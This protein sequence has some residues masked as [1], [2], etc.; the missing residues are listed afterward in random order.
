MMNRRWITG[1]VAGGLVALG[2]ARAQSVP[3]AGALD[4][5]RTIARPQLFS[6]FHTPVQE[7]YIWTSE[8]STANKT[9]VIHYVFP[10]LSEKTEPHY[11]RVHFTVAALP[12]HATLYI[13]GPRSA[14][15]YLNGS[16][17]GS[18]ASDLLSPLDMHVFA[19]DVNRWLHTGDNVLALEV[20]AGME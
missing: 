15:I 9:G 7:Q 8:D 3:A 13:A 6:S 18:V 1:V 17:A 4:P 10:A 11:F 20:V 16:A 14:E 5:T 19:V 2:S 12:A